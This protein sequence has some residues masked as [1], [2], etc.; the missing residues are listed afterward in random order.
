M[1]S[2]NKKAQMNMTLGQILWI[3]LSIIVIFALWMII[4]NAKNVFNLT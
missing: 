2:N 3:V 1:S 4:M